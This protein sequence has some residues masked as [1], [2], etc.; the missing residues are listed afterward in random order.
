LQPVN[1]LQCKEN[2]VIALD[3]LKK[4][5]DNVEI[6]LYLLNNTHEDILA[7]SHDVIWTLLYFVMKAE[8]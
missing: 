5:A 6:P 4:L 2:V 7:G 8:H 3:Y 1:V